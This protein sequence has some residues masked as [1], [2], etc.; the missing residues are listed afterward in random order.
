M[1]DYQEFRG[2][3][4]VVRRRGDVVHRPA[5]PA[6]PAIHRLLQHVHDAG[7]RGAP[8]P[9]GFDADGNERL[10]F[11]DGDV[12]DTLTPQLRTPELLTSAATLLRNL[13]DAT[14]GFRPEP[15]D[16]WL[17]KVRSPVEV[18]CHGDIAPYNSVVRDGLTVGFIDFDAAHPGPRVWDLAYAVYRYAP[19]HA[20]G[21]P[22][23]FGTAEEQGHRA[24]AFCRAYGPPAGADV[25]DVVPDR[26]QALIDFMRE[27]AAQ[28]NEAFQQHIAEGHTGLYETDIRYVRAN[29]DTL[30]Q[31][32]E[33]A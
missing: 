33:V 27:Q 23:S 9:L 16:R 6:A 11:L 3:V 25:I 29:R 18:M 24:A 22:E 5:S 26:L 14:T 1:S 7:F 10:T 32:F 17:F 13:H 30:R 28:G 21:N 8:Q 15:G 31:A 19:L 20:P 4:N 2:G 12:H